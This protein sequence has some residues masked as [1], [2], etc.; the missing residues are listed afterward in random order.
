M[1]TAEEITLATEKVLRQMKETYPTPYPALDLAR[2]VQEYRDKLG[3]NVMPNLLQAL[4]PAGWYDWFLAVWMLKTKET[5][6]DSACQEYIRSEQELMRHDQVSNLTG[7]RC[8]ITQ[9][10]LALCEKFWFPRQQDSGGE[11]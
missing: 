2:N 3:V 9:E 11:R 5:Y 10:K 4:L 8:P 7:W 6:G 1:L